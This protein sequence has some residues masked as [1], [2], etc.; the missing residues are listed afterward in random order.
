MEEPTPLITPE[1]WQRNY[2][3]M[4]VGQAVSMLGSGLVQFALVW[5][6]TEQ[7]GS[8]TILAMATFVALIP[9]VILGPFAGALV[10]RLNRKMIMIVS[11]LAVALATVGLVILFALG[12]TQ[13][14]HIYLAMFIRSLCGAF[15]YPAMEASTTLMVPADKYAKLGGINQALN[16]SINII[17]PPLGALFISIM[18]MQSVLAIDLVTAALAIA[19]LVF[20]VKV[21]Q[22]V[23]SDGNVSVTPKRVWLDVR[24]GLKYAVS[25]PGL[26]KLLLT[27]TLLNMLFSPAF[28]LMPLLVTQHFGKGAGEL[29]WL[30]SVLGIGVVVGGLILG[31][32][33]GFKRKVTTILMGLIG[34]GVG[35]AIIGIV[36]ASGYSVT[37]AMM[38]LIGMMNALT[39]G[40][41][42]ALLQTKIPAEKQ[43][44]IFTV[45][46]SLTSAASPLGMLLA[47]PVAERL[48]IQAWYLLAGAISLVM[49]VAGFFMKDIYTLDDQAPGGALLSAAE[50]EKE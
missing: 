18:P 2:A 20:F 6:L 5:Y 25:W 13:T 21:P 40:P 49:G 36:P 41:L 14:W 11:D 10:D 23:L 42:G 4:W 47:A 50:A 22:P 34:M 7:T 45:V 44:R 31:T 8:A 12:I 9:R 17:S 30:E 46:E 16:G 38:G 32:W 19:L 35:I 43:G 39:N 37:V 29:A 33:G 48:G 24:E 27:A 1:H 3:P 26:I 28:S 15:Q